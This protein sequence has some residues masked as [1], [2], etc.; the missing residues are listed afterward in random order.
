MTE[1]DFC[2]TVVA[3]T[4]SRYYRARMLSAGPLGGLQGQEWEIVRR[5]TQRAS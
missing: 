2:Q 1:V 3:T 5:V 4:H